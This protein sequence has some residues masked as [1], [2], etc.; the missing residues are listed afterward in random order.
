MSEKFNDKHELQFN[1]SRKINR[2]GFRQIAPF[3]YNSSPSGYSQGNP[4]IQPEF[5]NK[6]EINYDLSIPKLTWLSSA[7]GSY[8]QQPI[9]PYTAVSMDDSEQIVTSYINAN[10]SFVY[11]WEN[12][13]KIDPVPIGYCGTGKRDL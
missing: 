5:D 1:V 2:P 7:Y 11:G 10:N 3:I 13:F 8:N 9:T 4:G 12:T 6:A